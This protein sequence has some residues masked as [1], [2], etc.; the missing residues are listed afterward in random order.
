VAARL[1][2]RFDYIDPLAT[3]GVYIHG[4]QTNEAV[5]YSAVVYVENSYYPDV[6]IDMTQTRVNRHVDGTV[7]R[8]VWVTNVSG[9]SACTVDILDISEF[10]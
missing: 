9:N 1:I 4:Y 2:Y 7:A 10:Y 3:V 6:S 5:V 8:T